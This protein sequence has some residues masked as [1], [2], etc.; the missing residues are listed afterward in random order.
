MRFR[1]KLLIL[2]V[3]VVLSSLGI[4]LISSPFVALHMSAKETDTETIE[5]FLAKY[6]VDDSLQI[7]CFNFYS[8][9]S[10]VLFTPTASK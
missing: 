6:D 8:I 7:T 10:R 5:S 9:R 1:E 3:A 4:Y 2:F